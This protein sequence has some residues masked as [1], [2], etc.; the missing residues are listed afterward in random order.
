MM[1]ETETGL[2]GCSLTSACV[3][4]GGLTSVAG[5]IA[6]AT[7]ELYDPSTGELSTHALRA[8]SCTTTQ[9]L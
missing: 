7:A 9:P 1:T 8:V 3:Q 6:T 4:V 2:L 5:A